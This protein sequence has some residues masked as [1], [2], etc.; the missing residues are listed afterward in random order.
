MWIHIKIETKD[1]VN[2]KNLQVNKP[3]MTRTLFWEK[4][5]LDKKIIFLMKSK[6]VTVVS[7]DVSIS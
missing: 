7:E 1:V 5:L 4:S 3:E 2:W 6:W